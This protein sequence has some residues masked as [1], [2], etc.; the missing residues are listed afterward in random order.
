MA[1]A[2]L[3]LVSSNPGSADLAAAAEAPEFVPEEVLEEIHETVAGW[4]GRSELQES[5][6]LKT[7]LLGVMQHVAAVPYSAEEH[8]GV[9]EFL[10]MIDAQKL[11]LV[12]PAHPHDPESDA[13]AELAEELGW[14]AQEFLRMAERAQ[15]VTSIHQ[16]T[17]R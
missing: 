15:K 13:E 2:N 7:A 1:Q 4:L 6:S 8:E 10:R 17:R 14:G 5:D 16:A 11:H 3:R 12:L 9:Q